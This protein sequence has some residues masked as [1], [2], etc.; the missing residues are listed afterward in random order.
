MLAWGLSRHTAEIWQLARCSPWSLADNKGHL[1]VWLRSPRKLC[2]RAHHCMADSQSGR[3]GLL[4]V[5]L[6]RYVTQFVTKSHPSSHH[7]FEPGGS[8]PTDSPSIIIRSKCFVYFSN[9]LSTT[10]SFPFAH[11]YHPAYSQTPLRIRSIQ[12]SEGKNFCQA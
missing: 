2:Q 4:P 7:I 12:L 11:I 3:K 5:W 1:S 6:K 9:L 10:P 8:P